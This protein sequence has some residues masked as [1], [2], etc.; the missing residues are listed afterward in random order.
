MEDSMRRSCAIAIAA[1]S[2]VTAGCGGGFTVGRDWDPAAEATVF[3]DGIDVVDDPAKLSGEW[4]FRA[5]QDLD[6]RSNLADMVAVVNI[7]SIQTTKDVDGTEAQRIDARVERVLYGASPGRT[8]AL[9]SPA[10]SLGYSLITRHEG[11]LTGAY[12]VFLRWFQKE[13]ETLGHHFHFSP[14]SPTIYEKVEGY[15]KARKAQEAQ[16]KSKSK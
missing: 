1:L 6:E 9:N 7:L 13:D 12:I 11:R 5:R 16:S 15:V 10:S 2:V 14:A 4:A 8:L 3:D